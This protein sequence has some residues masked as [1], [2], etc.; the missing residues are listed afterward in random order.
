MTTIDV[1]PSIYYT[2][3]AALHTSAVNLYNAFNNRGDALD[4]YDQ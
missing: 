1:Q 3:A 2:A 4:Q